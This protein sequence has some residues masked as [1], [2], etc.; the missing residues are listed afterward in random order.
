MN[1]ANIIDHIKADASIRNDIPGYL[2][3]VNDPKTKI[4]D[5]THRGT[6]GL[7]LLLGAKDAG[8]AIGGLQAAAV[9][10]P[11]LQSILI[12]VA[13]GGIDFAHPTVQAMIDQ[14]EAGGAFS[15]DLAA[16]LRAVGITM[17][18]EAERIWGGL[19]TEQNVLDAIAYLDKE[20]LRVEA[21][22]RY[23]LALTKIEAGDNKAP[24][25]VM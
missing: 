23:E 19:A 9:N 16:K 5:H 14:L 12:T 25:F 13:V 7:V 18:S 3:R 15:P 4:E 24:G 22:Q 10:N 8:E 2:A 17:I 6:S 20:P 21:Q 11:L 1:I